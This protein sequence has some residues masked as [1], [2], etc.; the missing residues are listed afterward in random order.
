VCV[1]YNLFELIHVCDARREWNALN[2]AATRDELNR[3]SENKRKIKSLEELKK[4]KEAIK[5]KLRDEELLALQLYT[6]MDCYC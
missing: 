6:G 5:A 3:L 2:D 1:V 4:E